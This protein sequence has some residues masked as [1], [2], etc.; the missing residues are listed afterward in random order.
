[1]SFTPPPFETSLSYR[2]V[3]VPAARL[4]DRYDASN[5]LRGD[6]FESSEVIRIDDD[7]VELSRRA[8]PV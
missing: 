3:V 1:L 8:W 4:S 5:C 7:V 2:V 6:S